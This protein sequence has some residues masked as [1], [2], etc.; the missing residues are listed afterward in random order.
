ML[1]RQ[2]SLPCRLQNH[3]PPFKDTNL[4]TVLRKKN[5]QRKL[6]NIC[7][8]VVSACSRIWTHRPPQKKKPITLCNESPPLGHLQHSKGY[9]IIMKN[10][11]CVNF[12]WTAVRT[13]PTIVCFVQLQLIILCID[14]RHLNPV[15]FSMLS[16]M[17][18]LVQL[19]II[20]R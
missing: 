7:Q 5:L 19:Q 20:D 8:P 9:I 3:S 1:V 16:L 2:R 13:M 11:R 17:N 18:W 6:I 14:G 10:C 12:W 4:S 15:S